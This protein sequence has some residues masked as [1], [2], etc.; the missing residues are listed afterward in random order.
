MPIITKADASTQK[1]CLI[2]AGFIFI[3]SGFAAATPGGYWPMYVI[4]LLLAIPSA[5]SESRKYR[6]VGITTLILSVL[7]IGDDVFRGIQH[8]RKLVEKLEQI[9]ARTHQQPH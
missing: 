6:I 4:I 7:L 8:H 9:R 2:V 1:A 5:Q 3:L